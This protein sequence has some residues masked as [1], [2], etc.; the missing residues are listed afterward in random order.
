MAIRAQGNI[1]RG[2]AE[3]LR[4]AIRAHP[5]QEVVLHISSEGG[6]L[7]EASDM[8]SM[9]ARYRI[10]VFLPHNAICA[11]ACFLLLAAS[12]DRMM[13]ETARVGGV[14]AAVNG[15]NTRPEAR[16]QDLMH[17]R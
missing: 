4:R 16:R 3:R 8:A 2:D 13:S 11:S 15:A 6:L 9:I 17:P 1:V 14:G 7:G 12:P 10:P 5:G